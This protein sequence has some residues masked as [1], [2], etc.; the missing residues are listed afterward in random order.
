MEKAL[1]DKIKAL[2][3]TLLAAFP[4][5]TFRGILRT[6]GAGNS[7]APVFAVHYKKKNKFG[8]DGTFIVKIGTAEWALEEQEFYDSLPADE[9]LSPL[10]TQGLMHT[11]P[12]EGLAAV[13]YEVA[14]NRL[15]Q[16]KTLM[17]VLDEGRTSPQEAQQQVRVLAR[18]LVDWYLAGQ[19]HVQDQDRVADCA[20]LLRHMLTGRRAA[21]LLQK[22]G[23]CVQLWPADTPHVLID[24]NQRQ[25]PN[26]LAYELICQQIPMNPVHPICRIHGDLHTGNVICALQADQ[27]PKLIDFEQSTPDGVP[28]FDLAYLEFDIIRHLLPPVKEQ[29]RRAA[30]LALLDESMSKMR[31]DTEIASWQ[32]ERAR[33]LLAPVREEV[34]RLQQTGG[35]SYELV[36]WLATT[37]VGLNF[38]RKGDET[39]S[40]F[41]RMAGLLYA[42]Y[43]LDH[44]AKMFAVKDFSI[45]APAARKMVPVIPWLE[46]DGHTGIS[47]PSLPATEEQVTPALA[48]ELARSVTQIAA[49]DNHALPEPQ[50]HLPASEQAAASDRVEESSPLSPVGVAAPV[51]LPHVKEPE[52]GPGE[53]EESLA[54]EEADEV[55]R[56]L[57]TAVDMFQRGGNIYQDQCSTTERTLRRLD[58]CVRALS[59]KI[60]EDEF[61]LLLPQQ[62]L[63]DQL[64]DLLGNLQTF[65][66][67]CPPAPAR[68]L[69]RAAYDQKCAALA[70]KLEWL[71]TKFAEFLASFP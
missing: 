44:I 61:Y 5:S 37:A 49:V 12:Q 17:D 6:F 68:K 22:L 59:P 4:N 1:Q 27:I 34:W 45:Q 26:P 40:L 9:T 51:P 25:L 47:V 69:K 52:T 15:I 71:Q 50:F 56:L 42:A 8:L 20:A 53:R 2:Q 70:E 13:A 23:A 60:P 10:L 57:Q 32:A 7:G 54:S 30:W 55:G 58:T 14:F 63:L 35:E 41:E 33:L 18:A 31:I 43:G 21:N 65:R 67:C 28:F 48:E 62:N 39:R 11:P 29:E 16:P 66:E 38:A 46:W 36:W 64:R 24:G 19:R 3:D